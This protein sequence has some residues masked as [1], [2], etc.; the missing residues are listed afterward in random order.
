MNKHETAQNSEAVEHVMDWVKYLKRQSDY[1]QHMK[2]P[3]GM[4]A[5]DCWELA[6]ELEQFIKTLPK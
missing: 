4:S 5:G 6:I 1:G 3:S 2:I